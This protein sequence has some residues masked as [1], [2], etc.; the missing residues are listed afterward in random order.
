[1]VPTL[2]LSLIKV[3]VIWDANTSKA[4]GGKYD[5][6]VIFRRANHL[7]IDAG[8]DRRD[9]LGDLSEAGG[10]AADL[11]SLE[12]KFWNDGTDGYTQTRAV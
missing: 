11:L 5:E 9:D 1:M 8:I 7:H 12:E 6:E 3:K 2:N 4:I 10:I